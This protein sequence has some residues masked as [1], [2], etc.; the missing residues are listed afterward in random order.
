MCHFLSRKGTEQEM[1]SFSKITFYTGP[2]VKLRFHDIPG[3]LKYEICF[4]LDY[5]PIRKVNFKLVKIENS[6]SE[7]YKIE[8]S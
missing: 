1:L 6:T 4:E 5:F 2:A 8:N 7:D 3:Q